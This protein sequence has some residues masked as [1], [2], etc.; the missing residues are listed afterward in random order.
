MVAYHTEGNLI[1][2]QA[3]STK[4]DKQ[5]YTRLQCH[6]DLRDKEA[7]ADVKRVITKTWRAKFQLVP[8]DM[9][10]RNKA[11]QMICHFK[12]HF[13]S[14]LSGV[15]AAFLPSLWDLLLSQ[16]KLP[17]N[18]LRQATANPKISV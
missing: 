16:A 10:P 12:N 11:K 4:A 9:H 3:F 6:H 1:L 13:L 15:D 7:S 2:Q 14:I 8:L 17:I 18:L 5:L